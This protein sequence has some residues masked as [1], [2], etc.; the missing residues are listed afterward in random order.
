MPFSL[1]P[2][3]TYDELVSI[4]RA[5][6]LSYRADNIVTVDCDANDPAGEMEHVSGA[7]PFSVLNTP[8][9][10]WS[11]LWIDALDGLFDESHK[12]RTLAITPYLLLH[13]TVLP[14][15]WLNGDFAAANQALSRAWCVPAPSGSRNPSQRTIFPIVKS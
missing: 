10:G 9:E 4:E 13:V 5:R 7:A 11:H 8:S 14:Q 2:R 1:S 3:R 6:V 12:P 15:Y